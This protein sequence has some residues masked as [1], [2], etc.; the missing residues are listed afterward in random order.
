MLIEDVAEDV[1]LGC[2]RFDQRRAELV[3]DGG[4]LSFV[5]LEHR[6]DHRNLSRGCVL[7]NHKNFDTIISYRTLLD[8]TLNELVKTIKIIKY[9]CNY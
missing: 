5:Q 8:N 2:H 1:S 4:R 7:K 3:S 6:F 9:S